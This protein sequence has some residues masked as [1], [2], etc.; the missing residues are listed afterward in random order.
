MTP[1]PLI[2]LNGFPGSDKL[3]AANALVNLVGE[4]KIHLIDNHRLITLSRQNHAL[5]S[6]LLD[7]AQHWYNLNSEAPPVMALLHRSFLGRIINLT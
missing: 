1:P 3:T 5:K 7:A 2:W 6:E 4:D